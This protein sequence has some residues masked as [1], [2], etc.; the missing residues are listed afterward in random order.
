[1]IGNRPSS[2][3]ARQRHQA[4][5]V[6]QGVAAAQVQAA[7]AAKA[8]GGTAAGIVED[9]VVIGEDVEAQQAA[10]AELAV[11]VADLEGA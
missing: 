1:M 5:V 6:A 4:R 3:L 10:L 2:P 7:S 8:I 11:R 9:V